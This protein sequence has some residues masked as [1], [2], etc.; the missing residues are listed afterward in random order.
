M[1]V[2]SKPNGYKYCCAEH[3]ALAKR[4]RDRDREV[5]PEQRAAWN[6]RY[7]AKNYAAVRARDNEGKAR[8]RA[9]RGRGD[10]S[11]EYDAKRS[12]ER[13][14]R[15][16]AM[17]WLDAGY[18]A[19]HVEALALNAQFDRADRELL[20][21][22]NRRFESSAEEWRWRYRNEPEFRRAQIQRSKVRKIDRRVAS[23][24][25]L[26]PEQVRLV[27]AERSSCLYCGCRLGSCDRVLDHMDPISKGGAHDMSN[28][29]VTCKKC[30]ARKSAKTFVQWLYFV[31]EDRRELIANWYAMKRGAPAEQRGRVMAVKAA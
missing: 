2:P 17:L 18:Y 13:G 28:L 21:A 29:V 10:R 31:P 24:G 26:T 14:L 12:R 6:A 22:S 23:D 5:A 3:V 25:T 20:K 11:A 30:N 19:A 8:A 7:V 4:K 9:E 27:H 15:L 1:F 16:A